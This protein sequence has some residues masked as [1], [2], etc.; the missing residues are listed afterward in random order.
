MLQAVDSFTKWA[1]VIP[2][3][4]HDPSSVAKAFTALCNLW[5]PPK[6]V[7]KDNG[8]EFRNALV[9]SVFKYFGVRVKTGAVR[10]PQSPGNAERF[11]RTLLGL[12]RT[13]VD[14]SSSWRDDLDVLLW[15]YVGLSEQS[16]LDDRSRS[17]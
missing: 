4:R 5:D 3:A 14:E 9:E 8:S 11:N 2:L 12:I 6:V 7:R 13:L 10:H 17:P 16:R 1:E 15:L